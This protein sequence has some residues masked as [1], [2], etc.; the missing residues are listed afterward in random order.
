MIQKKKYSLTLVFL[1]GGGGGSPNGFSPIAP[2]RKTKWLR[3]SKLSLLH[4]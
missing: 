1:R 2:E 3:A 4:P